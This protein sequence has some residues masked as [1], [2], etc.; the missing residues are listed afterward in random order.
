M[1]D[2]AATHSEPAAQTWD[3]IEDLVDELTG[4]AKSDISAREF[5]AEL[6]DRGVRAVGAEAGALWL[7]NERGEVELA[8]QIKCQP[9]LSDTLQGTESAHSELLEQVM[10]SGQAKALPPRSGPG[11]QPVSANP[12]DLLMIVCPIVADGESVGAVELF[13]RPGASPAIQ[14]GYLQVTRVLCD[15]AAEF[16]R[17]RELRQL[18]DRAA[19]WRQFDE[20]AAAVHGD[21]NLDKTAYTIANEARR[22]IDCDRVGVLATRGRKCRMLAISGVDSVDRRS[23]IVTGLE[24][25]AANVAATGETLWYTGQADELPA[26]LAVPL[27]AYCDEANVRRLAIVPLA[28]S[29]DGEPAGGERRPAAVLVFEWIRSDRFDDLTEQRVAIVGRHSASALSNAE[30]LR[31]LPLM[32]VVRA[33][34]WLTAGRRLSLTML[35]LLLVVGALLALILVPADFTVEGRGELQPTSKQILYAPR[36]G[37]VRA[38]PFQEKLAEGGGAQSPLRVSARDVLVELENSEL[39]YEYVKVLGEKQTAER[40]LD[41]TSVSL[42][43]RRSDPL[44]SDKHNELAA[45]EAELKVHIEGLRQRL[46][47]LRRQREELLVASQIDGEILTW[48]VNQLLQARPVRRGQQ[49]MT[50]ADTAGDWV[51]QMHVP[52]HHIRYVLDARREFGED[53]P[54]SFILKSEPEVTYTGQIR[55]VAMATEI[56]ESGVS[57]V[58]VTVAF[59]RKQLPKALLRPGTTAIVKV[60]CGRRSLGFVWLHDLFETVRTQLLF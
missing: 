33:L 31:R 42:R 29:S 52:D 11:D 60:H 26:Q 22:L 59:D 16:H 25:L 30:S 46:E 51:L 56:D 8:Y 12:T 32:S 43:A 50:I 36:D 5:H 48:D 27:D 6:L 7:R 13:Q 35:V 34:G 15:L 38:L 9:T 49:L 19:S 28:K 57:T 2:V 37:I 40:E 4:L 10:L 14:R 3:E 21:V 54:V 23:S 44:E 18:R 17:N 45:K 53:L 39:E 20:F 47:I 24:R 55:K 1:D 41:T 58:L